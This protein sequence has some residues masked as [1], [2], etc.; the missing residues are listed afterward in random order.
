MIHHLTRTFLQAY[1]L[2]SAKKGVCGKFD[3]LCFRNPWGI[4]KPG[5]EHTGG[6]WIDGGEM[7]RLYPEAKTVRY[8]Q[9]SLQN[10]EEGEMRAMFVLTAIGMNACCVFG[11]CAGAQS[12]GRS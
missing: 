7:W 10:S 8:S 12:H 2:I 3:L 6:G 1:S 5:G 11:V 9:S 4:R